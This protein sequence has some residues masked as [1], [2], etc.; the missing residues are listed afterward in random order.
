MSKL[1][2]VVV[3]SEGE[4]FEYPVEADDEDEAAKEIENRFKGSYADW[5]DV[6]PKVIRVTEVEYGD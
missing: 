3:F 5:F 6:K 1:F 4:Y 2:N